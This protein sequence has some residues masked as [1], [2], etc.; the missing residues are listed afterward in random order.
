[1]ASENVPV[2]TASSQQIVKLLDEMREQIELASDDILDA[3]AHV[4]PTGESG[5]PDVSTAESRMLQALHALKETRHRLEDAEE[6]VRGERRKKSTPD[7]GTIG[8]S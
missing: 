7:R 5:D 3:A 4:N 1:M 6:L 2:L 8:V